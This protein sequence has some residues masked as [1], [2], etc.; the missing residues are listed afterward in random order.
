MNLSKLMF[1]IGLLLFIQFS[2]Q[3]QVKIGDNPT[4]INPNSLLEMES[5]SMGLT[6][7][8]V[9]LIQTTNQAPMTAHVQGMFVY[10]T[11]TSNDVV[12]GIYYNDG[13]KWQ[14]V[15]AAEQLQGAKTIVQ[16]TGMVTVTGAG[17]SSDPYVVSATEVDGDI[18]N[19]LQD[20]VLDT[21]NNTLSLTNSSVLVPLPAGPAGA[22][23][24]NGTNGTDGV[25]GADGADGLSAFEVWK[26]ETG[27]TTATVSDYLAAIKGAD[28]AD[29]ADGANGT[30]GTDGA[31]G[32]DG[33]SAYQIA[34][35]NGYLGSESDWLASLKGA[36]GADGADG[37]N[38]TN[39]TDGADGLSAFEVWKAETGNTTAT[40]SDYLA[41]IKGAD[42]ADGADGANGTNGTDG[43]DG[44]SAFE[45]WKIETGDSTATEADYL[46][47]I[48]GEK[49][50]QGD[51]G[52][53]GGPP[54]P[55]GADGKS[56]YEVAVDNGYVGT[57]SQWLQSLV[58]PAGPSDG[59]AW[60]VSGEDLN[61]AIIRN[62]KTTVQYPGTSNA[63]GLAAP[64]ANRAGLIEFTDPDGT[65]NGFIG[66][67]TGKMY[68]AADKNIHHFGPNTAKVGIGALPTA[69]LDVA[70][71]LRVRSIVAGATTDQVLSVNADGYVRK[72]N[73]T[74]LHDGD[75][76]GVTGEDINSNIY[77][78]GNVNIGS[79]FNAAK[80]NVYS[81]NTGVIAAFRGNAASSEVKLTDLDASNW[82]SALNSLSTTS[83]GVL[84]EAP[85]S[86]SLIFKSRGNDVSDGFYFLDRNGNS[87]LTLNDNSRVGIGT[88][89]PT[90]K[91]H[92]VGNIIA[93]GSI[94]PNSDRRLKKNIAP[95]SSALDKIMEIDGVSWE[96]KDAAAQG[97]KIGTITSGVIAQN[98]EKVMPELVLTAQ[99]ETGTKSVNYN[100]LSAYFIEAIK[101]QQEIIKKQQVLLENQN[102]K[103]E[104][105]AQE[106]A[107]I[108]AALRK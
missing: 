31:D 77:R 23:G 20:L 19:E 59:D 27:N 24:I 78:A 5:S 63:V 101:S 26:A 51:P 64:A 67:E 85:Q 57:E 49:G 83:D 94:T 38:G 14:Q 32:V 15:A 30:N 79:N 93:T 100:G 91:L 89:S 105:M 50:D 74:D 86:S 69:R 44:L 52:T 10:N 2:I 4:T 7:P 36:D 16:G 107:E 70:G 18:S 82:P 62:G 75:A 33:K 40:V 43:A 1:T 35:D 102:E 90:A 104:A 17:T 98:V 106:L 60:A 48:K 65:R 61:S 39:G 76:W 68:Y 13:S 55:Q 54:G 3:A 99:D 66:W 37:T 34:V 42:G 41:A 22:D 103:M 71:D 108:K 56:A 29:G 28:G 81:G 12:P 73:I 92:V 96:W 58:G 95:V 72:L 84:L 6:L 21:L 11:A 25:D 8:R 47:A 88:I 45:V 87:L 53:P 9:A 80:L 97:V 46:A